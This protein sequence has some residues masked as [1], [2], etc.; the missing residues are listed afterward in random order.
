M[1][2][3]TLRAPAVLGRTAFDQLFEQ[4]FQDPRPLV[5]RTTDGYPLTD[6]YRDQNDNQVIE[7]ALAGFD[8]EHLKIEV[9]D[10]TISISH[11]AEPWK[12]E[13]RP[14][15]RIARRSFAKTFVDYNNTLNL[16]KTEASFENGLL[17]V[18]IPQL[19]EN[20]P[21]EIKIK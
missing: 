8:K 12:G 10:N 19:Q 5:K 16:S 14:P 20:K 18:K 3:I 13:D 6:V 2:N 7:M 21:V 9:K 1:T 17:T 11:Q 4:F 15:R